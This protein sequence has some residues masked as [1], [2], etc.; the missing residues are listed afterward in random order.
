MDCSKT[1]NKT[2]IMKNFTFFVLFV[3]SGCFAQAENI[4]I[5][6]SAEYMCAYSPLDSIL[7]E[8]ISQ[9]GSHVIYY[10]DTVLSNAATNIYNI[11]DDPSTFYV[12]QNYPNPFAETTHFDIGVPAADQ[13]TIR[14][15]D[16]TGRLQAGQELRLEPG[17]HHFSFQACNKQNYILRVSAGTYSSQLIMIQTGKGRG[18]TSSITYMGLSSIDK[19]GEAAGNNGFDFSPGDEL[20]FTGYFQ[21]DHDI[22]TDAPVSNTDYYFEIASDVPETPSPIEGDDEVIA[23][24]TGLL[25]EVEEIHGMHY[26]WDVP[27]GWTITQGEGTH[28]ILV[29]AGNESGNI[30]VSMENGCGISPEQTLH[31]GVLFLLSLEANPAAA[32]T[33]EGAGAYSAGE[34]ITISAAAVEGCV[35]LNWSGDADSIDDPNAT[36]TTV[37]MPAQSIVLTANFDITD[38]DLI[39]IEGN[40]YQSIFIG[41]YEWMGENLRTTTYNDGSEIP[42]VTNNGAW[43]GLTTGAYAWFDNNEGHADTLGAMYNWHAVNSGI[44]CPV[45]WRIPTD[46]EWKYLEGTIDSQYPVGHP[47]WDGAK[48]RGFDVGLRM[49]ATSGWLLDG[50]GTDEFDFTALPGGG[51]NP[52]GEFIFFG[53]LGG[54]WSATAASDT[55]AFGRTL[56]SHH[57]SNQRPAANKKTGFY[58]RCIKD[59]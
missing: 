14:I 19:T 44:L 18:A 21:G 1:G 53:W 29:D 48:N 59:D 27:A 56:S 33:L 58:V 28:S 50:N 54:W 37:T 39:D 3:T 47:V 15:Y 26:H 12:S 8:N 40:I 6:F 16:I 52:Q 45:G 36:T 41:D 7:I 30:V 43:A 20:R 35:F 4:T 31:I 10:P 9:G 22:I 49:K 25:Y 32:G 24:A 57:D 51:R 11:T 23:N 42:N 5:R 17:L 46:E 38:G 2:I 13:F 34:E 55:E